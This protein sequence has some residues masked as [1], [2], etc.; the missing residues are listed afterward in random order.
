VG[1]EAQRLA[2]NPQLHVP[3]QP[4]VHPV[5]V[6][7][8]C[9]GGR[10]EELHLHLLE[11]ERPEDEVARGDL[12]AERL[13]D[14][15]DSERRLLAGVLEGGLEVEEDALRGLGS[16]VHGR[17]GV[18]HRADRGL[19]HEVELARFREVAVGVFARELRGGAPAADVRMLGGAVARLLEVVGAEA[20]L[21]GPALDE[22]VAEPG[23]MARGLP[24]AR[25]LDDRR[26]ERHDVVA[27]LDHRLPPGA[28]HVVL[29]E[30]AVVP[31][32]IRVGDPAVDL[33]GGKDQAATLA[34]RNDLVHGHGRGHGRAGYLPPASSPPRGANT[35]DFPRLHVNTM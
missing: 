17:A 14:L 2:V 19:E 32:V 6:P 25:V 31:V 5:V 35:P 23:E 1:A 3:L 7:T 28:D 16:E 29:Q 4:L 21:A 9:L 15:R 11:L 30:D 26:V 18:L 12:V 20:E 27:L 10:H 33:G 22:R 8:L 34:E 13:T 24:G